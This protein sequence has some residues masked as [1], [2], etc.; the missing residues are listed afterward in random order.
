MSETSSTAKAPTPP[1]ITALKLLFKAEQKPENVAHEKGERGYFFPGSKSETFMALETL[2]LVEG[3]CL[4]Y[5]RTHSTL[6]SDGTVTMKRAFRTTTAGA[7][8]AARSGGAS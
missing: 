1:Q 6:T 5:S 4:T 3:L 2:G 7:S 8:L